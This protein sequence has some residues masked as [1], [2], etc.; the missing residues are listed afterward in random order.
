M[1]IICLFGQREESYPG[2]YAPELLDAIDDIGDMDNADYLNEAEEKYK[3]YGEFTI[4][5]RITVL[6]PEEEFK[7]A[8]YPKDVEI[9]GKIDDLS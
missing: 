4:L 2:Q 1:K 5:K 6:I 7:A 3:G 9:K 8:F